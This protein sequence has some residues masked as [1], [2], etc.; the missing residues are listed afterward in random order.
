MIT[1]KPVPQMSV[2]VDP[3]PDGYTLRVSHDLSLLDL[4]HA[5]N[6]AAYGVDLLAVMRDRVAEHFA[7]FAVQEME[8]IIKNELRTIIRAEVQKAVAENVDEFIKEILE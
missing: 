2:H 1:P 7:V 3:S 4:K 6:S 8:T 5:V